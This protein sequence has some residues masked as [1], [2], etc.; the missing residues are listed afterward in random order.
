[1]KSAEELA[2]YFVH[3]ITQSRVGIESR[4]N[5]ALLSIPKLIERGWELVEI[6]QELDQFART[7][8][9]VA[10]NVYHM[11]EIMAKIEPPNNL[12]EADIFYYHN[13]LREISPPTRIRKNEEGD[14]VRETIPFYL[15]M[16]TC[17]SMNDLLNY[18]YE[19][20]SISPNAHMVRQ[21]EGKFKYILGN[22]TIDEVLFC[23]DVSKILRKERQQ[24]MLR[25]AFDLEKF[26]E[27]AR[28][29][30]KAKENT[31]KMQGINRVVKRSDLVEYGSGH[32]YN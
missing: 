32:K 7:Y 1:M 6:K 2:H 28:E 17:F 31:H 21:D 14:F 3:Y 30:M 24:Q 18:W 12:M 29:F 26:I 23:I 15:E 5:S 25:N 9:Q 27:E 19:Q 11:D 4:I 10:L 20:M 16:K 13:A 22:Y 8:P